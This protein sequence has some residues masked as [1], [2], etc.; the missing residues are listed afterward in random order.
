MW[1]ILRDIAVEHQVPCGEREVDEDE[2]DNGEEEGETRPFISYQH[3]QEITRY[4]G[5]ELHNISSLIGG[6][7]AQVCESHP[8]CLVALSVVFSVSMHF[9]VMRLTILF[10]FLNNRNVLR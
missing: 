9:E 1:R 10:L 6:V 5:A 7:A 8:W 4:G 2:R 3:A